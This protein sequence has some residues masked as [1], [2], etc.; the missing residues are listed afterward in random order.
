MRAAIE[1][2]RRLEEDLRT[3]LRQTSPRIGLGAMRPLSGISQMSQLWLAHSK[4][5]AALKDLE[6]ARGRAM[7]PHERES[8]FISARLTSRLTGNA[9]AA[10]LAQFGANTAR[11]GDLVYQ[12]RNES[13]EV[14]LREGDFGVALAPEAAAGL[15]DQ[16]LSRVVRETELDG[17]TDYG[18]DPR[19]EQV[20]G[21]TVIALD[22]DSG[23]IVLRP[24][25]FWP[26]RLETAD[27]VEKLEQ[28]PGLDLSRDCILDQVETDF[29]T[30]KLESTL[31]AI[32][33]PPSAV[34]AAEGALARALGDQRPRGARQTDPVPAAD[35]LWGARAMNQTSV[36]RDTAAAKARLEAAGLE[37]NASQWAAWHSALSRRL[38]T[39]W[40]PPGTGK[41]MTMRAIALGAAVEAYGKGHP[42]RILVGATTYT[43]VDNVLDRLALALPGLLGSGADVEVHR[44]RSATREPATAAIDTVLESSNPSQRLSDLISRLRQREGVTVVGATPEQL[45]NMLKLSASEP[46]EEAF[47]LL[48]LDE[49]SQ[50]N[51]ARAV[52]FAAGLA[53]D[54]CVVAA[55]DTRQLPP[56]TQAEAPL[57]F[58]GLVGP[59]LGLLE[60]VYG[61]EPAALETNYRSNATIVDLEHVAG[62]DLSLRPAS[63]DLALDLDGPGSVEPATW[64][65]H[66][67][68]SPDWDELLDPGRPV[69][70]FTYLDPFFSSQWNRFEAKAVASLLAALR[71]RMQRDL[72]GE[73]DDAGTPIQRGTREAI[74][75]D[76]FWSRGVGIVTPHR[77]QQ[78]LVLRELQLAFPGVASSSLRGAVDTVERFQGQQRDLI[79]VTYALG[80][81]D[82][83]AEEDEF[84]MSFSRFNVAVSRARAKLIVIASQQ[85]V[86][87]LSGE[88]EVLHDSRLLKQ[89]MTTFCSASRPLALPFED[90]GTETQVVGEELW[91]P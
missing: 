48:L 38:Q 72:L 75:D 31:K 50:T 40:G 61:I 17:I 64:P 16:R 84:L 19:M 6:V 65:S 9:R 78:A 26:R 86:S 42:I 62:Y 79:I 37:L 14:K 25:E 52:L 76:D 5:D 47:D 56:I 82:A 34:A 12:M 11:P 68:W 59:F 73:L 1:V 63:P 39:I 83:I 41:S 81:P 32:K 10:A 4:V 36:E 53:E 71:P 80:D 13:R 22:R 27:L 74:D 66:L 7:P 55:G 90:E 89:F 23:L 51:V 45:H 88:V 30:P 24:N 91:R 58:E 49:A 57:G 54:G 18:K 33:N 60:D 2:R 20:L 77:A 43:A 15:L 3:E 69:A 35:L 8:R 21:M 85:V 29:F 70:A 67:P 46:M 44:L 87:H 28:L